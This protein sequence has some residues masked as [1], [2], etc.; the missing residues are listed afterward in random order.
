VPCE[1]A[2]GPSIICRAIGPLFY[3]ATLPVLLTRG[4]VTQSHPFLKDDELRDVDVGEW[5]ARALQWRDEQ[6]QQRRS[7]QQEE[8]LHP[9]DTLRP[10]KLS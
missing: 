7:R 6:K 5:I 1:A 3:L 9:T 8:Q 2:G 10:S 4:D